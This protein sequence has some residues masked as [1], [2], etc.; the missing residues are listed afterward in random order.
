MA[1]IIL[2]DGSFTE[3]DEEDYYYLLGFDWFSMGKDRRYVGY[4]SR[5]GDRRTTVF[6]HTVVAKRMGLNSEMTDHRDRNPRNNRRTNLRE[7]DHVTNQQNAQKR[8]A[9]TTSKYKGVYWRHDRSR[10]EAVIW[11]KKER[12]RLGLHETEGQAAFAY[13]QAAKLYFGD[14]ACLN[15]L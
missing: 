10:W 3:V 11:V 2:R 14:F 6:M 4:P 8:A 15:V 12:I 9:T 1:T 5:D 13:N 7:S